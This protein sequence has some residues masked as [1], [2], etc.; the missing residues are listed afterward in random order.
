MICVNL[1]P[2]SGQSPITGTVLFD[3]SAI[4]ARLKLHQKQAKS[5]R[6]NAPPSP[7]VN[8]ALASAH[9]TFRT[10]NPSPHIPPAPS[11]ESKALPLEWL[12]AP[13]SDTPTE[14]ALARLVCAEAH[15]PDV[16]ERENYRQAFITVSLAAKGSPEPFVEAS[17]RMYGL[18]PD[19]L[20]PAIVARRAW[21]L[22]ERDTNSYNADSS[23]RSATGIVL[24]EE[25][26][27]DGASTIPAHEQDPTSKAVVPMGIHATPGACSRG[28]ADTDSSMGCR[29][30]SGETG[31]R[32]ASG[33]Q[34][35]SVV[36]KPENLP[37]SSSPANSSPRKPIQSAALAA[38]KERA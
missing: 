12:L 17:Y 10:S 6:S 15:E 18:H 34:A 1:L 32:T 31:D 22:G 28:D 38:L 16:W 29:I 5:V 21:V 33:G 25:P 27:V 24:A 26:S 20:W 9:L 3:S 13:K 14:R 37:D 2:G 23:E 11:V 19:K 8:P 35:H 36:T 7:E 30:E 4:D